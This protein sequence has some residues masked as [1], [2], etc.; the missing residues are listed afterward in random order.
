MFVMR[1]DKVAKPTP[2]TRSHAAKSTRGAVSKGSRS[3][4]FPADQAKAPVEQKEHLVWGV[5][6]L[7]A[8][9][10]PGRCVFF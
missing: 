2:R 8:G 5:S 6:G 3:D 1:S 9:R 10:G 7:G 4:A